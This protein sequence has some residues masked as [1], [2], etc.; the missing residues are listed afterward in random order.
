MKRK[1]IDNIVLLIACWV[2]MI[3][4][5]FQIGF[6]WPARS[7]EESVLGIF[8]FLFFVNVII[9]MCLWYL[10]W[11]GLVLLWHRFRPTQTHRKGEDL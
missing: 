4:P 9:L 6:L 1:L 2:S 7:A 3:L 10:L 5:F 8:A 11:K